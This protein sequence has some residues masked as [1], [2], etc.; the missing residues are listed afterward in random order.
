MV[1]FINTAPLYEVWKRSVHRPEWLVVEDTPARLNDMLFRN[2]LD[3]GFIS[4]QEYA[5]HPDSY[6]ILADL[7]I[8]ASGKVG[9]VNLYS[10]QPI[11]ELSREIVLLSRQSQTSN[12]LLQIIGEQF[13]GICPHYLLAGE[14]ALPEHVAVLAIGD[15]ALRL[16]DKNSYAYVYDLGEIWHEHT[17]L[18]F[19]FAVWAVREEFCRSAMDTVGAIHCELLRCLAE[20]RERLAAISATVASR[21]PMSQKTCL[22]YL[23]KIEHDLSPQKLRGMELFFH[24]LIQ[25]GEGSARALPLKVCLGGHPH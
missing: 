12:A 8:S 15:Q 9:S 18:P 5:A 16:M 6:R 22:D 11:A 7:S 3:L 24:Y 14:G 25:R 17:G 19:V 10:R 21:I 2:E 4:S 13:I 1:N 20:G 23:Q